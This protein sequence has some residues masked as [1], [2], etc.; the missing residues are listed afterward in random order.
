MKTILDIINLSSEYLERHDID[1]S[2]R[3]AE[4]LIADV[5]KLK[6]LDLYL[7]F[8]R[9][10]NE[11]EL[12]KCREVLRRRGLGEPT[13]YIHGSV[14]FYDCIIDV[15][16]DVL[17]P[18]Q[19]TELLVD[20]MVKVLEKEDLQGKTLWDVC[21]GSGCIGI[22]LKKRFPELEIVLSDRSPFALEM[23][24]KN[25]KQ[26]NVAVTLL[27]GDLFQPFAGKKTHYLVSN[28]PYVSEE[29][30]KELAPEVRKY[31]PRE[32]LIAGANGLEFYERFAQELSH[33]LHPGGKAWF[34]IGAEQGESVKKL[35][36]SMACR[37]LVVEKDWSNQDRFFFLEIQ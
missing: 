12:E 16:T 17:I 33:Y 11:Q 23:A 31:E 7:Q 5:L 34:E 19:E 26:N 8:D 29:E 28:P 3:E 32:A 6:R 36:E 21:C 22:S 15:S 18:R 10:L 4:Q 27:L 20:K 35:F 30:Y 2:R 25:A 13:Q 24:D 1:P 37:H 14:E 9:P